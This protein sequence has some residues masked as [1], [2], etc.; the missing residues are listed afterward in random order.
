MNVPKIYEPGKAEE[1]HIGDDAAVK[2]MQKKAAGKA[3]PRY[4]HAPLG[5][6]QDNGQS[7]KMKTRA[8]TP[9]GPAGS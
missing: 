8:F 3:K 9:G 7:G 2:A 5:P 1:M 6:G 4:P